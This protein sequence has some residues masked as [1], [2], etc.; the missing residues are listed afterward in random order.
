MSYA[1]EGSLRKHLPKIVKLDWYNKLQLLEKIVFGL[2]TIHESGL[3]H[4]D[5]HDGNILVSDDHDELFIIDLGLC[6]P[7]NTLQND[8]NVYGVLP[9]IAPEILRR[10]SYTAASDIYSFSMIMWEFTSGSPP[11]NDREQHNLNERPEIIENTPPCYMNLMK[12]CWDSDP[13]KRPTI[14][15]IEDTISN[16]LIHLK[17]YNKAVEESAEPLVKVYHE[18][19]ANRYVDIIA[20]NQFGDDIKE[21]VRADALKN[22]VSRLLDFAQLLQPESQGSDCR[23]SN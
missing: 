3:V 14:K 4:C 23:I 20:D 22:V 2:K 19:I 7:I 10:G 5:L 12:K 18:S 13:S 1:R 15:I 21:F 16:W 6:K 17:K 9:Y 11:F 8:Y